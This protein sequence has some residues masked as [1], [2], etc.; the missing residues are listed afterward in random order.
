MA[1]GF[2]YLGYFIKPLGYLI[3]D[4][5]WLLRRFEHKISHWSLRLLSMGGRLVLIKA[6]LISIPVFWMSLV[7]IPK[8]ILGKLKRLIF[9]FLWGT[10]GNMKKFHLSYWSSLSKPTAQGG[11]GIKNLE[12]FSI[13]LWLKTFWKVLSSNGIWFKLITTKYLKKSSVLS[14]IRSK[15]FTVSCV[16]TLWKGFLDLINWMGSGLIWMAGDGKNIRV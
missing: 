7:P 14:W 8:S 5:L 4:W 2:K 15:K 12:W 13:S 10:K 9:Y 6:V 3:N 16:S 1:S 11:W